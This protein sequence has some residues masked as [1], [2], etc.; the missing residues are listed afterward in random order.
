MPTEHETPVV[1][2]APV[3]PVVA[4]PEPAAAVPPVAPAAPA[5]EPAAA[6]APP[7]AEPAP[8]GKDAQARIN[9]L[10][11]RLKLTEEANAQQQE[12]INRLKATAPGAQQPVVNSQQRENPYQAPSVPEGEVTQEDL[13]G[14]PPVVR[15]LVEDH[16]QEK[17]ERAKNQKLTELEE[18]VG[19]G[20][21]AFPELAGTV[22]DSA[23]AVE[24]KTRRVPIFNADLVFA[25]QA[26]PVVRNQ[27][28]AAL[29]RVA[30]LEAELH[31]D[32]VAAPVNG[33]TLPAPPDGAE[34]AYK[35]GEKMAEARRKAAVQK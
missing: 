32:S 28:D 3:E 22:D 23:I 6:P 11:A 10:V 20:F 26:L 34:P 24:L 21:E 9:Q 30:E 33:S 31:K 5:A 29:K 17:A 8:K 14:L 4:A 1:S 25:S 27:R 19:H 13:D 35:P 18:A 15:Q 7:Q 16:Q 2:T 12:E